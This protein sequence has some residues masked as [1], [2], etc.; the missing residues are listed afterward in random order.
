LTPIEIAPE[1]IGTAAEAVAE[2]VTAVS[3]EET[4]SEL[5]DGC[6]VQTKAHKVAPVTVEEA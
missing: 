1:T 2:Q 4:L 6:I 3:D 5:E